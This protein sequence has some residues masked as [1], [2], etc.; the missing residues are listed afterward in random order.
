[1]DGTLEVA[2]QRKGRTKWNGEPGRRVGNRGEQRNVRQ[3]LESAF[4]MPY[5][6]YNQHTHTQQS[7]WNVKSCSTILLILQLDYCRWSKARKGNSIIEWEREILVKI[8]T[9]GL[10]RDKWEGFRLPFPYKSS[11]RPLLGLQC[12]P[13]IHSDLHSSVQNLKRL[14]LRWY[15]IFPYRLGSLELCSLASHH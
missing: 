8:Y 6:Q 12:M 14:Q 11:F 9:T 13:R 4:A 15:S 1:M 5:Q 2:D 7:L 3:S 10:S